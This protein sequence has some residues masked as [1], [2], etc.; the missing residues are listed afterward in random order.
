MSPQSP[1]LR[2]DLR[3]SRQTSPEGAFF[4]V[5]DPATG[6]FFRLKDPE[7]FIAHQL[8]GVTPL[9]VIR[10]RVEEKFGAPVSLETIVPFVQSL[11]RLRLLDQ[12]GGAG[13]PLAPRGGRIRGSPL[14][15]RL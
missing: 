11:R 9:S 6:R 13:E 2:S 12:A 14:Y 5:K 7:Y 15:L 3:V 8:D 10:Q 1:K 4:V